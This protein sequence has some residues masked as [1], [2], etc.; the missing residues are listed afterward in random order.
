MTYRIV[1]FLLILGT[2]VFAQEKGTDELFTLIQR[3]KFSEVQALL[4]DSVEVNCTDKNGKPLLV[5]AVESGH[6]PLIK[7][8]VEAGADLEMGGY[9]SPLSQ[10]AIISSLE[11]VHYLLKQG[12]VLD[13]ADKALK[14]ALKDQ[15][16]NYG[17]YEMAS[18]LI[19][20]GIRID[21]REKDVLTNVL[22]IEYKDPPRYN[23]LKM[24]NV[25]KYSKVKMIK[26]LLHSGYPVNSCRRESA[27]IVAACLGDT[28]SATL[29]L[30]AGAD[31]NAICGRYGAIHGAIE[32]DQLGMVKLLVEHGADLTLRDTLGRSPMLFAIEYNRPEILN[33]LYSKGGTFTQADTNGVGW[34][35]LENAIK[36]RSTE[37]VE[38]LLK[39][40][41]DP[42]QK[43]Q[44]YS[45]LTSA[46]EKESIEI[47]RLLCQYGAKIADGNQSELLTAVDNGNVE[48]VKILIE[49]GADLSVKAYRGPSEEILHWA[50][51]RKYPEV[52]QMLIERGHPVN[53]KGY[54]GHT[55]LTLA[56]SIN[57]RDMVGFLLEN[58]ADINKQGAGG[59]T[60]LIFATGGFTSSYI[61]TLL[62]YKP[63]VNIQDDSGATALHYA[64]MLWGKEE[65]RKLLTHGADPKIVKKNKLQASDLALQYF[66][67]ETLRALLENDTSLRCATPALLRATILN[68]HNE[69]ER[70]IKASV[71]VNERDSFGHTALM[72]A[73]DKKSVELLLKA[74][75]DVH[76]Q[77]TSGQSPLCYA[78]R[79]ASPQV[80]TMLLKAGADVHGEKGVMQPIHHATHKG[81]LDIMKILLEAGAN[82]NALGKD[83]SP[84]MEAVI[85]RK[86]PYEKKVSLLLKY[87]AQI[88]QENG[89]YN[90]TA[91]STAVFREDMP[92]VEFLLK[93]GAQ[94]SEVEDEL[95]YIAGYQ[96]FEMLQYVINKGA[97][98]NSL[99]NKD[100]NTA[101]MGAA[102]GGRYYT[103]LEL[104][105]RGADPLLVDKKGKTAYNKAYDTGNRAIGSLL[106]DIETKKKFEMMRKYNV[107]FKK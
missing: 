73:M 44:Y 107:K 12:A 14:R 75:A 97:D 99:K 31:V 4:T 51:S 68:N 61:D 88:S 70:L 96:S 17:T 58:N 89:E 2:S 26:L 9:N 67:L 63:D 27:L 90:I 91:L 100:K 59:M 28:T 20:K 92:A 103:V 24:K 66:N 22:R 56:L 53:G 15:F 79:Y 6:M 18:F 77:D 102:M 8:L 62:P 60:P 104:L 30:N 37:V 95:W 49:H 78:S 41:E 87:G 57:H 50:I 71:D 105:K 16:V 19:E 83:T 93:Q 7:H 5:E 39:Q 33:F 48:I 69:M 43:T 34:G 1:L 80:I 54:L 13:T 55:A 82:P 101:L 21:V 94:I 40:G 98:I 106:Y 65:I 25:P 3:K 11:I 64:A 35:P 36:D 10:A 42:N 23:L 38:V 85:D 76:S 47:V 29:L 86:T 52:V 81:R 32:K 74:G 72:A 46:V 45:L 84:L